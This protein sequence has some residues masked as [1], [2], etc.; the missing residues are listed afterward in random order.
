[1][2]EFYSDPL[3]PYD[4]PME[5]CYSNLQTYFSND[6]ELEKVL[7]QAQV[8]INQSDGLPTREFL[9]LSDI[10]FGDGE[11]AGQVRF[12]QQVR[13]KPSAF[14]YELAARNLLQRFRR[15]LQFEMQQD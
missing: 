5:E 2:A 14:N 6:A 11:L 12:E 9:A 3:F 8:R 4:R 7:G 15:R 1:M 10:A 13:G